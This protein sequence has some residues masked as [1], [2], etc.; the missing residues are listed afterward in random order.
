MIPFNKPYL[1][2][3]ELHYIADAHQRGQLAGDGH[4]TAL[5]S[6]WLELELGCK[7]ALLTHSCTAALEMAAMLIDIEPGD[8]I[9]MPSYTF[10]SS[11]NAFV[12]RGAVPVFVDIN[13]A[14][15]NLDES[16]IEGAITE[17]TRAILVVH[18]AG[19]SCAMAKIQEIAKKNGLYVIEDAAQGILSKYGSRH[20]GSIG[21]IGCISFHETKNIISGEGGAILINDEGLIE[22]AKVIR[23]KGTNRDQF[24]SGVIDKYTWEDI[25]SSFLPGEKTAAFLWAQ[26]EDAQSIIQRRRL[27]WSQYYDALSSLGIEEF[28]ALPQLDSSFSSNAHI[29]FCLLR[30]PKKRADVITAMAQSMVQSVF[31]YVPLHTSPAANKYCRVASDMEVTAS[32]ADSIVRLPLWLGLDGEVNRCVEA[33]HQA[34]LETH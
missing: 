28:A 2:G 31:H 23:Q 5:C 11:A 29:F 30:K 24:L 13:E 1:T 3:K 27:L 25:G 9:I 15:L 12:L 32:A 17:R 16:L 20:L 34:L 14:H 26:L 22:R 19:V 10:V 6:R 21:H 33:F 8:E 4:Y 7:K 18:Y